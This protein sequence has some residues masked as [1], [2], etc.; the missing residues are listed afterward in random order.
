MTC[1]TGNEYG[2]KQG[3]LMAINKLLEFNIR[4]LNG[5]VLQGAASGLRGCQGEQ[6]NQSPSSLG[7][8][9]I[10]AGVGNQEVLTFQLLNTIFTG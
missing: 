3:K 9:Y 10:G 6:D 8:T 4:W 1:R 7:Y 2:E 5:R